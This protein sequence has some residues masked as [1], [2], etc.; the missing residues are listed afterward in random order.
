MS[1]YRPTEFV[2]DFGDYRSSRFVELSMALIEQNGARLGERIVRCK[3]CER[4]PDDC[5]WNNDEE[6]PDGFC[7]WGERRGDAE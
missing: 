1:D 3:D 5:D 4:W 6:E 2:V 7:A